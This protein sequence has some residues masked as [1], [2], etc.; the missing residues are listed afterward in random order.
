MGGRKGASRKD[1]CKLYKAKGIYEENKGRKALKELS[2]NEK[3]IK[4]RERRKN[5]PEVQ[6]RLAGYKLR[7]KARRLERK[8]KR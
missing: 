1:K 2:K 7:R 6:T 8:K 4:Q 3:K 5:N